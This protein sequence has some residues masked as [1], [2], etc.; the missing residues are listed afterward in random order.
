M[1]GIGLIYAVLVILAMAAVILC[2]QN[3]IGPRFAQY[4][5]GDKTVDYVIMGRFRPVRVSFEDIIEIHSLPFWMIFFTPALNLI[6]RA[7]FARFVLVRR[8]CGL[9]RRVVIT[10]DR[11]D[12]FV[13]AVQQRMSNVSPTRLE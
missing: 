9:F 8:R 10:P 6:N 13:R 2:F 1:T 12:E 5:I 7:F 11:A 4:H 3:Y